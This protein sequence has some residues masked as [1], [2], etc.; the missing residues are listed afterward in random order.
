MERSKREATAEETTRPTSSCTAA[1]LPRPANSKGMV[2]AGGGDAAEAATGRRAASSTA[3]AHSG[4]FIGQEVRG[5][6]VLRQRATKLRATGLALR[7]QARIQSIYF[8]NQTKFV[9]MDY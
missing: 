7:R 3:P 6:G 1:A 9:R 4:S 5:G 8:L 2:A